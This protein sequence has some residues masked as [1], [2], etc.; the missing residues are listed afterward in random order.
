M[1]DSPHT[2]IPSDAWP[3]LTPSQQ[4]AHG[5]LVG[6]LVGDAAGAVLEF[7]E[8]APTPADCEHA[9]SMPGGGIFRL[10]P[11]QI[12]DDGEL[13]ISLL[14]ALVQNHGRYSLCS[15]ATAYNAWA[16]SRPFD[17]GMATASALRVRKPVDEGKALHQIIEQQALASN[18]MSK[19]N[20]SLMRATPLGVVA[21]RLSVEAAVEMAVSDAK[22]THPNPVCQVSTAAYVLAIRHLIQHPGD[23][24]GACAAA[25]AHA[26]AHHAEVADWMKDAQTGRIGPV[27]AMAGFVKHAFTLAFF[28]LYRGSDYQTAL[29]ETLA[30][31]GDTD[32]NACIVGG[33][34]GALHGWT[35]IPT[36]AVSQVLSCNTHQGRP[37]PDPYTAKAAV[38]LIG[39]L[40]RLT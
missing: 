34:I 4:A 9:M 38:T 12:T 1:S 15:V 7:L 25:G 23:Q 36:A 5:A 8:R 24:Q 19:A 11:G 32:T 3:H 29:I 26:Q 10:A 31:G 40:G 21:A 37:R 13:T 22:L 27:H 18:A 30:K 6:A 28:H 39:E 20:G 17:M 2:F 14:A 16:M 33:L 35:H